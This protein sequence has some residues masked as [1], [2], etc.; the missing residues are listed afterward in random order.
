[1]ILRLVPKGGLLSII[2]WVLPLHHL[3]ALLQQVLPS[4]QELE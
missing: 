1:M 2:L 4:L 3:L